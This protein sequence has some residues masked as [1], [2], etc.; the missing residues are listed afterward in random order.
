MNRY[1]LLLGK[2]L[3]LRVLI[4]MEYLNSISMKWVKKNRHSFSDYRWFRKW[5]GGK[6]VYWLTE[7]GVIWMTEKDGIP[8]CCRGKLKEEEEE[9][10]N[11]TF[12]GLY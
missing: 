12:K 6:W 11:R 1:E 7:F 5:Y 8:G 9:W 4:L 2:K 10:P 3:R